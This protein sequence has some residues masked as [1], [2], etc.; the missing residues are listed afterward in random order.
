MKKQ[1]VIIRSENVKL[2]YRSPYLLCQID[3]AI[4]KVH[5]ATI[6]NIK[7]LENCELSSKIF[8]LINKYDISITF[9]NGNGHP[10]AKCTPFFMKMEKDAY[11]KQVL[12]SGENNNDLKT[13]SLE[14]LDAK[15]KKRLALLEQYLSEKDKKNIEEYMES[16]Y[17]E[18]KTASREEQSQIL[19]KEAHNS[20]IYWKYYSLCLPLPF[21]FK[22]RTKNPGE[23]LTNVLLNYGYGIFYSMIEKCILACGLD[24]CYGIFHVDGPGRKSLVYDM[25]EAFR[26]YTEEFI[27]LFLK[28]NEN[29]L[30]QYEFQTTAIPKEIKGM[31]FESW[32]AYNK[33]KK[34]SGEVMKLVEEFRQYL[35]TLNPD[36]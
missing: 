3:D 23:D 16:W 17:S 28:E 14:W 19:S 5:A 24:P 20:K 9:Q 10:L 29:L 33:E 27:L 2:D 25:I 35:I 13:K 4:K 31:M 11:K 6:T 34:V 22:T 26:H 7:V 32:R 1:E 36:A 15:H 8:E 18:I 12:T 21:R 30:K